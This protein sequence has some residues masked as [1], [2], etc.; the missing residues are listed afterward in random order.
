MNLGQMIS[1]V[2]MSLFGY[3]L[4]FTLTLIGRPQMQ[5]Y[6]DV[7]IYQ[8]ELLRTGLNFYIVAVIAGALGGGFGGDVDQR[9]G[10][11]VGGLMMGILAGIVMVGLLVSGRM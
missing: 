3:T 11:S 1:G 6:F 5:A 4:I 9:S 8:S 10:A 2:L 7:Y